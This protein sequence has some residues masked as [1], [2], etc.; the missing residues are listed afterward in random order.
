MITYTSGYIKKSLLL[1]VLLVSFFAESRAQDCN[2]PIIVDLRASPNMSKSFKTKR[3][4][5]C[6]GDKSCVTFK[7]YLHPGSDLLS[8]ATD[9]ITGAG[10]Y[11]IDCGSLIPSGTAACLS[12]SSDIVIIT[13]CKPGGGDEETYTIKTSTEVSASADIN[14]RQGCTG[15]MS[16]NGLQPANITWTS[17]YP[18]VQGQYNSY[19]SCTSGC[20]ATYVT[21]MPG[22]PAYIDYQV[23]GPGAACAGTKTD[24]IRVYTSPPLTVAIDPANPAICSDGSGSTVLTAVTTGGIPPFTYTWSDGQNTPSITVNAAGSYSVTVLDNA[25]NCSPVS[26][27]AEVTAIPTPTA[28]VVDGTTICS[29]NTAVLTA[30][31][32]GGTY[33]WFNSASGGT[34]LS[35]GDSFITPVLSATTTYYVQTTVNGCT[36]QRTPVTVNVT[37]VPAA[38]VAQGMAICSNNAVTLSATSPGGIYQWF[39]SASGGTLL[40]AGSAF[41]TPVLTTTTSYYV[42][43]TVNNCTSP[44]TKVTV[45]VK[46]VP[47]APS[48]TGASICSGSSVKLTATDPG[49]NYAWFSASEGGVLLAT[50]PDFF[51]PILTSTTT[52][53]V[54]TTINGCT[55]ARSPVAVIVN[56]IPQAPAATNITICQYSAATLSVTDAGEIYKWYDAPE[57]GNLLAT[58][59]SFTTPPL[60]NTTTYYVDAT[61]ASGCTGTRTAVT[62]TVNYPKNPAFVYASGTYCVSGIDPTPAIIGGETGTFSAGPGVVFTDPNTGEIDLSASLPG[63][64]EITFIANNP[65]AYASTVSL[66]ITNAPDA[67]FNYNGSYCRKQNN[68]IPAFPAGS[69]AG[70]FSA[71]PAGLVFLNASTGEID[72]NLSQ[73]G[74]YTITNQIAAAS[75]CA[76]ASFSQIIT[77]NPESIADAGP[78]QTI[79]SGSSVVL[80]GQIG[81]SATSGKWSGGLGTFSDPFALNAVYTP[82]AGETNVYL[83]LTADT[84]PCDGQNNTMNLTI[85]PTP[86]ITSSPSLT[87]CNDEPLQYTITSSVSGTTFTWSRAYVAGIDN[88]AIGG[89]TSGVINEI[90]HNSTPFPVVVKYEITPVAGVCTGDVFIYQVTVNPTP[91]VTSNTSITVCNDELQNYTI[92]GSVSNTTFIWNRANV[93]G[94]SNPPV[95]GQPGDKITETLHNTTSYPLIVTYEIIPMA[96]GC[97]GETFLYEV[98]VNPSPVVSSSSSATICNDQPQNYTITSDVSNTT[99]SWSRAAVSEISNPAVTGQTGSTITETLH[100]TTVSPVIVSYEITPTANGC[101]GVPFIYQVTVNPTPTVTSS[102]SATVCN[103]KPQNY[104]ITGGSSNTTFSWSRAHVQGISNTAVTGRISSVITE[105]L[106]NTTT[107]PVIVSYE[108]IPR[109]NGCTGAPFIYKVTVN[110]TP[111]VTSSSSTTVCNDEAQNYTITGGVSNTT[112]SWSRAEVPGISNPAVTGQ[113]GDIITETLH[114]MMASPLTVS[115]EIIPMA[116]GCSGNPF[117]Y[118]VTVNPTPTVTSSSSVTVCND[119]PL[120]YTITGSVSNSTFSWSRAEAAGISNPAVTGQS[121]DTI[122]ETLHNNTNSPVIVSYQIIPM[123]NGCT[124]DP[125]IYSVTVNPTPGVTSSLAAIVCNDEPQNYI[126]TDGVSGTSFTWSRADVAGISNPAVAGQTGNVISETLHNST[127]APIIVSYEITPQANGCTGDPFIYKV[128]VNP[129]PTISSSS[130]VIVCNDE[131]Q[132]YTITS[133]VSNTTFSWSRAAVPGISNPAVSGQTGGIIA[134]TLHNDTD[135]PVIVSYEITPILN[136][137]AGNAFV[138]TV[139]VNPTPSVSSSSSATICN[140]DPQNYIITAEVSGTSFS[141]SRADVAGI[142]NPAVSGQT[143]NVITETLHNNTTSP[144]TVSYQIIPTANGCT[145]TPFTYNVTVNPTPVVTSSSS[146]TVCSDEQQNYIIAGGVT[147]TVFTWSRAQVPGISNAATVGQTGSAITETLHN[148]TAS[149]VVVS[150]EVIPTANGCIGDP[151]IYIVTVNPTPAVTNTDL[152]KTI[153]SGETLP[154]VIL[155]SDVPGTTFSW[156]A[157]T[158]GAITGFTGSGNGDIPVQTINNTSSVS[159]TLTYSITPFHDGCQGV[160]KNLVVEVNPIP[161][162]PLATSNSPVCAG[163]VLVLS[164]PAVAGASYLWSGPNGFVSSEQNPGL[165]NLSLAAAGTY[166]VQTTVNGCTSSAGTTEVTVV[167]LPSTPTPLSNSPICAGSTLILSTTGIAGASYNWTGPN[168]FSSSLQNPEINNATSAASG[169]YSLTVTVNGCPSAS[170][171]TDVVVNPIPPAPLAGSNSPL[172]AGSSL[173]LQAE[174]LT[175]ATYTW[176][177]PN[178]FSSNLRNPV[179]N[180]ASLADAGTY[181]VT[182]TIAGCTGPAQAVTVVINTTPINPVVTATTPVCAGETIHFEATEFAGALYNWTGPAGFTSSLRN[183]EINNATPGATGT[184]SVIISSPGCG[185]N[186]TK[187]VFVKVN[188]TPASIAVS[189]NGPVCEGGTISLSAASVPGASYNWTGPNGFISSLQNPDVLNATSLNA[190]AYRLFIT[191]D[192]CP[193]PVSETIVVISEASVVYAGSDQTVCSA[194][195]LVALYGTIS[196]GS[197]T[198]VW[199]T[200]GSGTFPQGNTSLKGTYSPSTA[201]VIS[202]SIKLTLTSTNNKCNAVAS[203]FMVTIQATPVIAAGPDQEVCSDNPDVRLNGSVNTP[204]GAIWSSSGTGRFSPSNADLN[205]NYLPGRE[206]ISAGNVTLRLSSTGNGACSVVSDELNISIIR[207]PAITPIAD[208]YIFEDESVVLEPQVSGE[209]LEYSWAPFNYLSDST[210]RN[211]SVKG[212]EDIT[213]TL[214]VKGRAGCVETSQISVKVLKP[215]KIPNTFTP[216]ND[217]VNDVFNI[218]ELDDYPGVSV[219]IFNRYGSKLFSSQGY[220]SPWDGTHNGNPVPTGVYYYVIDIPVYNKTLSGYITVIK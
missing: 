216:N 211:P 92:T 59:S 218:R 89:Q 88:T 10:F 106:H 93:G 119:E 215:I 165:P 50:T 82:A 21:P 199:S 147:N 130:S 94:I 62:A 24:T 13:Y 57:D 112:F 140:D 1:L 27:N 118:K 126:I 99:F 133:D 220:D 66:T 121:D 52:Y 70:T 192:G 40:G 116:N 16:V 19:L 85:E 124:G 41:T 122:T 6:C 5:D 79:C 210:I 203:S 163:S 157:T 200:S 219:T 4:G 132:N 95:T 86:V 65:C 153:C 64:Y 217:G 3:N 123:A 44:R 170:G 33:Q 61:S 169:T 38:P 83:T 113:P 110:P 26:Q 18:G 125:F 114:N 100:N 134:E 188:E 207:P 81:G 144:I 103:D 185:I 39:D 115:Y 73:A 12:K 14:L 42:Q 194:S 167:P 43:T 54:Q 51:T 69:S 195:P 139:T 138:Y 191:V 49:G 56:P 22:A 160:T 2:I 136:G 96:N 58:G 91:T 9:K 187:E 28:P 205:A 201:D 80:N 202:G 53:Y 72:L 111:T 36:S 209:N 159:G 214:T 175:G 176:T 178:G 60:S 67:S 173:S 186:I 90:L 17:I 137:C 63:L 105:T 143:G 135:S 77:I 180:S 104:A 179:I 75:G 174:P 48:A 7:I 46:P 152:V 97:A 47:P 182:T 206:D 107:S 196:G 84:G 164:T 74:T 68:A 171:T 158:S 151:F 102:S 212:V 78:D 193:G 131:Q 141:W 34:L 148:T 109:A 71:S 55:S 31:S 25:T 145:G 154:A 35:T 15:E 166:S 20:P 108:I 30:T 204:Y 177:G 183:P 213:Y 190:G 184:Y 76:E 156:T 11:S 8:F 161:A 149:P 29:G 208:I 120:N 198:G 127:N 32:P 162:T 45:T 98:T 150:Y 189:N 101:T 181:Y 37:P 129:T 172:C 117:I 128:T 23:S 87:V 142:S 146:A 155:T 168:G 197:S